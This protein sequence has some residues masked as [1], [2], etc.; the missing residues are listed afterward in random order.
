MD[1]ARLPDGAKTKRTDAAAD[2]DD[3][4]CVHRNKKGVD[5]L[6]LNVR[7]LLF[8]LEETIMSCNTS[9]IAVSSHKC[10]S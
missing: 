1:K 7:G 6:D 4:G 2:G 3:N 10:R 8:N 9:K 5:F